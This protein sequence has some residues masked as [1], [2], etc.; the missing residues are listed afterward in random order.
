MNVHEEGV[1]ER[2][3][4]DESLKIVEIFMI[5]KGDSSENRRS[6]RIQSG[7]G[8]IGMEC[9]ICAKGKPVQLGVAAISNCREI[10]IYSLTRA[11]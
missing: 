10:Y 7:G 9:D 8:R 5:E 2:G 11:L 1:M 3:V 6:W 4:L